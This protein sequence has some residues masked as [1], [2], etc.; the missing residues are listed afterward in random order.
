MAAMRAR[1]CAVGHARAAAEPDRDEHD[2]RRDGEEH[3]RHAPVHPE[4]HADDAEQ[5]EDVA[6]DGDEAGGEHLVERV[7]VG[8]HARHQAAHR[9]AVEE[10]D[11]EPL[12]VPED[13]LCGGRT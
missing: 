7:D 11:V 12:Q 5:H 13:L 4:Q 3:Q 2:E 1:T 9:I 8:G 10:L 6:E